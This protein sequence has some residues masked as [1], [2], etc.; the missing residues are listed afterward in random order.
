MPASI[1]FEFDFR[2]LRSGFGNKL[3][4][5]INAFIANYPTRIQKNF[6]FED[7]FILV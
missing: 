7:A 4:I 1:N 5:K 6:I 3:P 2:L